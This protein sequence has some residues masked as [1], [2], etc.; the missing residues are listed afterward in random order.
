[1]KKILITGGTVFVSRYIAEYYT[2]KDDE[3]YV[4]NRNTKPQ[5]EGVKLIE[6]DRHNIGNRLKNIHF[7]TVIDV[8]A[9]DEKDITDLLSALESFDNYIMI[10]SSAVYPETEKQPFSESTPTGE[11][12]YWG[13]Y[14]TD[15]KAAENVLLS[16]VPQAYILRPPYLYGPM[17][18]LYREAF[19]FDCAMQDRKFCLPK[20]GNMNLQFYYIGDLC[21]FIDELLIEKPSEHIFNVG[22]RECISI[23]DWVTLCYKAVGKT[24]DFLLIKEKFAQRDYFCF[25]DYEYS[26]DTSLHDKILSETKDLFEG[27][28]ES[29]AWYVKN[30]ESVK[31]KEYLNFIDRFI[32]DTME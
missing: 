14:G 31:K 18:N 32:T 1:M 5:S 27:L 9:Y 19:V 6:A 30:N 17:N 16:L 3:V 22:N 13:S 10:S 29:F 11:N 4:L 25:Y 7:D 8:T 26:L 21:K 2:N 12:K 23:K 28:K 15:K 24:A 20:E